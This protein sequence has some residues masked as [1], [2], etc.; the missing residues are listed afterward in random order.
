MAEK[1]TIKERLFAEEYAKTGN[2]TQSYISAGYKAKNENSAS[3]LGSRLLRKRRVKAYVNDIG[4]KVS[5]KAIM[6][7]T[8]ALERLTRIGR[9]E[10]KE[11]VQISSPLGVEERQKEA[12]IKARISAIKEIL[13]RY[14]ESDTIKEL[15]AKKLEY[16]IELTKRKLEHLDDSAVTDEITF[17]DDVPRSDS[18]E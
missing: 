12:D 1:L 3:T 2:I 5:S 14:P 7:V 10:E 18:D 6:D 17:I 8:E 9:G 13:K 16:E 4:K 15:Q 11:T